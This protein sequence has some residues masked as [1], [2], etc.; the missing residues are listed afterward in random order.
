MDEEKTRT[1]AGV[2]DGGVFGEVPDLDVVLRCAERDGDDRGV[3]RALETRIERMR[4]KDAP[5][6]SVGG[7]R[8]AG[9]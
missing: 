5:V 2:H 4:R 8:G 7:D 6:R 3:R 9:Q 1:D